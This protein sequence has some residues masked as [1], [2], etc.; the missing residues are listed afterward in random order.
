MNLLAGLV[1]APVV[2][3]WVS[4]HTAAQANTSS[5]LGQ[6]EGLCTVPHSPAYQIYATLVA[7][8]LPLTVIVILNTKIYIT[9]RRIINKERQSP[10]FQRQLLVHCQGK[11][12]QAQ[13][14]CGVA[15]RGG[16]GAAMVGR[17]A[18]KEADRLEVSLKFGDRCNGKEMVEQ[19]EEGEE[20][21]EVEEIEKIEEV[22]GVEEVPLFQSVSLLDACHVSIALYSAPPL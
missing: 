11:L 17:G 5:G 7:F 12:P 9:A 10:C 19:V 2:P 21:E 8:Y 20:G 4:Q 15:G 22:E 16:G 13:G 14:L 6:G 1:S 3:A 18:S